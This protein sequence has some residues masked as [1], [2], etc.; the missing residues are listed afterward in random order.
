MDLYG[1][2]EIYK[3]LKSYKKDKIIILSTNSLEEVEYLA[4][5]VGIVYDGKLETNFRKKGE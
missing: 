2:R 3:Y 5:K 4:D 1:K